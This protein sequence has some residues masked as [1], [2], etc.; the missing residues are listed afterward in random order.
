MLKWLFTIVLVAVIIGAFT[1]WTRKAG[2]AGSRSGRVPGD[3]TVERSGKQFVFPIGS[4]ILLSLLASL[5]FWF[6]R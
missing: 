1:P 5:I 6:L 4:T 3:I 2:R